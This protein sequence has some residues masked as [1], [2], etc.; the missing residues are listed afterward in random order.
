MKYTESE[1]STLEFKR[2]VPKNQ[3]I[4]K[5]VIGF[6][7][8]NGGRIV[9]G[10]GDD[11]SICGMP[12]SRIQAELE[13]LDKAI[14][15]STSPPILPLLYSR[16]FGEK[17]VLVIEVSKGMNKPYYVKSEGL[18]KGT[19]IRLGRNTMRA[20]SDMIEELKWQS[21]GISYDV[22][23]VYHASI[24]DLDEQKLVRFFSSSGL[25][26][27]TWTNERLLSYHLLC[28][29]HSQ[30]YPTVAGILLFAREPERFFPEAM[31][32]STHF[33]GIGGREVIASQD[34]VGTLVEQ[35]DLA[36]HFIINRLYR[37]F[38]IKSKKRQETLEIPELAIREILINAIIHRNYHIKSPIK[39]AIYDN[40]LEFFSPGSLPGP[41]NL[42]NLSQG[43]SY[44]RNMALA[45][46]FREMGLM[47]KLG[48]GLITAFD[49]CAKAQLA[50][51]EIVEGEN[52]VKAILFRP[53]LPKNDE[54]G[55]KPVEPELNKILG[56]LDR[57]DEISIVDVM[58]IVALSRASAG[59]RL[60]VLIDRG[61][62]KRIGEGK[63]SR[64]VRA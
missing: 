17:T 6:C 40:R 19:Y 21:R 5:T 37:A 29:E 63:A 60:K 32:I 27:P 55:T 49:A 64:Y 36:Y 57:S 23:P 1:S 20:N 35:L 7:N 24:K 12:E 38:S 53:Q 22:L 52:F 43:L 33:T 59:R 56:L 50:A 41:I 48:S 16:R 3:Q 28:Q 44:I 8:Q 46:V 11:G 34:C 26:S 31:T 13:Y 45:R 10:V 4:I 42:K 14:Y 9:V 2:E 30:L 39:I 62:L 25:K 58:S 18:E 47:E 61:L 15:E 54:T 51:P